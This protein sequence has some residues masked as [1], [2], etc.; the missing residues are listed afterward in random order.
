MTP[1]FKFFKKIRTP[2]HPL[3]L[4]NRAYFENFDQSLPLPKYDFVVCDTELTGLKKRR[5]EII[6][7]GAVRIVNLQ[8][9]LGSS[10]HQYIRPRNLDHNKATLIHRIT[11]EQLRQAPDI[12]E[13]LPEFM[14]FC[15]NSLLVGHFV[16]LDMDFLNSAASKVLGG[17]FSN[18]SIDTMRLAKGYLEAAQVYR[19]H[20]YG[21]SSPHIS[22]H[23]NDLSSNFNLPSFE[24]HDALEDAMQTAY[25][26]LFLIKKFKK[27]GIRNL[28]QLYSSGRIW[29]LL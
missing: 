3:L 22:Y 10:F 26:F 23:L 9:E 1:F 14:E 7:I 25:L 29:K 21:N 6:S 15:G 27:G 24:A 5:D 11:P 13:V 28:K 16:D 8:I 4:K 19:H 17:S 18:P 2:P 12:S 20:D